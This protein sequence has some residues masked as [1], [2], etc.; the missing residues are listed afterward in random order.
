MIPKKLVRQIETHAEQLTQDI[1]ERVRG[2]RRTTNYARLPDGEIRQAVHSVLQNLGEWLSSRRAGAIEHHYSKVGHKRRHDGIRVSEM[3]AAFGLAKR[4]LQ[5]FIRKS[6]I[7]DSAE[8][9][10]ETE[11]ILA[12]DEFFDSACYGAALGHEDAEKSATTAQDAAPVVTETYN[13][14]ARAASI[15][16]EE[17]DPTSR[18]GEIGE[19]GG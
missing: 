12:V 19:H 17:W 8:I 15:R 3:F 5:D 7:A 2:D 6:M 16:A 10:L 11:L 14:K 18:G 9:A 1:L 4:A 13:E